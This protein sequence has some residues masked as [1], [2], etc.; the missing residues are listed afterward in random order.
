MQST[1]FIL[2]SD[3][4]FFEV[5]RQ[6]FDKKRLPHSGNRPFRPLICGLALN[7]CPEM[8]LFSNDTGPFPENVVLGDRPGKDPKRGGNWVGN[9]DRSPGPAE[10]M[11]AALPAAGNIGEQCTAGESEKLVKAMNPL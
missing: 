8:T 7:A 11:N 9:P 1:E 2:G 6:H 4:P 3:H 10:P 5:D